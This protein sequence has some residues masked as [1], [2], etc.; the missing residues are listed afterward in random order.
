MKR[1]SYS[2]EMDVR[3]HPFLP[4][5][6]ASEYNGNFSPCKG[7]RFFRVVGPN[8]SLV[9]ILLENLPGK[10]DNAFMHSL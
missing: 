3:S 8:D 4:H 6:K 9:K 5:L 7:D 1:T 10:K 2:P